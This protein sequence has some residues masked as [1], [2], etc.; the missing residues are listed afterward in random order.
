M[1]DV[2]E[3]L[4]LSGSDRL[5]KYSRQAEGAALLLHLNKKAAAEDHIT[6]EGVQEVFI[7]YYYMYCICIRHVLYC[8]EE[9]GKKQCHDHTDM[10]INTEITER[11]TGL[12]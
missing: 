9:H 7:M 11:K 12:L 2:S 10:D 1:S 3:G 8:R 5:C 6:T 4:C